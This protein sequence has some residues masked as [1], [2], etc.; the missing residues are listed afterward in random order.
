[1]VRN[2]SDF[3]TK[4]VYISGSYTLQVDLSHIN[5]TQ[6]TENTEQQKRKHKL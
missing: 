2:N 3:E 4:Y 6:Q 1:M 5:V